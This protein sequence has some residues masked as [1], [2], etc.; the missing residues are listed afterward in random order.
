[1]PWQ[2]VPGQRG[3]RWRPASETLADPDY[4]VI[5]MPDGTMQARRKAGLF[6]RLLPYLIG[7]GMGYGALA[8]AGV[9]G[10][11][12]AGGGSGAS[13]AGAAG[14][15]AAGT[16]PSY[17]PTAAMITA[18]SGLPSV[19]AVSPAA[20]MAGGAGI[21]AAVASGA[22]PVAQLAQ[23]GGSSLLSQILTG[24]RNY[25]PLA[26]AGTAAARGLTQGRTPA[27]SQVEELLKLAHGRATATEPLFQALNRMTTAQLPK[28]T[29]G[30]Q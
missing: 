26:L 25:G 9:F 15:G 7:G 11:A 14:A 12:L 5:E 19:S 2:D 4:E 8:N 28:Y 18:G 13:G 20:A 27:E 17:G 10:S 21:P 30:E 29:R 6:T 3:T 16:L 24:L 22:G 1:M 23:G